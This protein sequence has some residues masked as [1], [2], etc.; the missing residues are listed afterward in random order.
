MKKIFIIIGITICSALA[1]CNE[2]VSRFN[3][4]ASVP[5]NAKLKDNPL[6]G[7]VITS[8]INVSENSMA[9]LYGND[10]AYNYAG[11]HTDINYPEGAV[12]YLVTWKQEDD[13]N[14]F[15]A[16]IP[17][18]LLRIEKVAFQ[19]YS[20][21]TQVSYNMYAGDSL[22]PVKYIKEKEEENIYRILSKRMAVTP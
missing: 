11:T 4:S 12:L 3:M 16:K 1:S 15:G 5:V 7:N 8:F 14:W 22:L 10:I 19:L 18:K 13:P 2:K 17:G 6:V 20:G 21:N 9:T